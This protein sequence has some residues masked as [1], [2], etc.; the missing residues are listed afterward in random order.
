MGMEGL[1][2]PTLWFVAIDSDPLSYIPEVVGCV[3]LALSEAERRKQSPSLRGERSPLG[4]DR[5]LAPNQ[6]GSAPVGCRAYGGEQ[7]IA[8][9]SRREQPS[10]LASQ[11]NGSQQS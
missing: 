1:E 9:S 4:I 5:W 6:R 11:L 2:P 3:W 7:P 10:D 8:R